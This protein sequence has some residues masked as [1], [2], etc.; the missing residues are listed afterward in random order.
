M[1]EFDEKRNLLSSKL[2]VPCR[3]RPVAVRCVNAALLDLLSSNNIEKVM[4]ENTW[5]LEKVMIENQ[6]FSIIT[7]S[8]DLC[9]TKYRVSCC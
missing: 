7:F 4:I 6:V 1:S 8:I 3:R 5:L 2:A 9:F